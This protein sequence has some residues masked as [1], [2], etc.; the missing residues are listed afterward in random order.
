MDGTDFWSFRFTIH[1]VPSSANHHFAQ[2]LLIKGCFAA[3]SILGAAVNGDRG[4]LYLLLLWLIMPHRTDFAA[5]LE[6]FQSQKF[7]ALRPAQSAMLNEY[8][9][10]LSKLD[11]GVELPTGAGKTLIALLICEL[12]RRENKKVAVL[13]A[14]KTLARQMVAEAAALGVP[15]VL[16]EGP[17]RDIPGAD[18]RAYHRANSIAVMNYWVYFNQNPVLDPAGLLVMDDAHLAE[19]CLHSLDSVEVNKHDH[20]A[21]FASLVEEL[22]ERFPEYSVLSDALAA[23]VPAESTAELLSF[24][25]QVSAANRIREIVDSSPYLET[26]RDL[27]FRWTRLRQHLNEANIYISLTSI[28][29]RPYVYP[30]TANYQYQQVEQRLYVSATIGDPGDLSRRLGTKPI[31]KIPIAAEHAHQTYGCRLIVMNRIDDEDIPTRLQAVIIEALQI[32]PKS[33]WLCASQAE[34]TRVEQIVAAWLNANGLVGHPTWVLTSLGNEIDEFKRA[35][36]GHLFVGGR[37]DGMD[38]NADECRLVVLKTLPRAINTQEEFI[39]AYLRDSGFMRRR[40]N[41]RIVQALGRCNRSEDDYGVYVLADRRFATHFGRES[42]REGIPPNMVAEIDAAQDHAEIN[43]QEQLRQVRLFLN[44]DFADFDEQNR[45]Y[46]AEL[47]GQRVLA[48]GPDTAADEVSGWA[49]LFA[50]QN[51]EVAAEK[52]ETCWDLARRANVR[53]MAAFHGWTW[54]K[55]L[56]LQSL[57]GEANARERSLQCLEAAIA[58]GGQSSWFNR[59]RASVN[60]ARQQAIPAVIP[61]DY[62][63]VLLRSFDDLLERV[64]S[65]GDRFDRWSQQLTDGLRSAHHDQFAE[66]IE[67]LGM[68]L[69]FHATRPRHQAATDC[70]WR[71]VFGNEKEVVTFEVKIEHTGQVA[72]APADVGQAHNQHARAQAQYAPQGYTIRGTIVSHMDAIEPAADASAGSIRII[73]QAAT[74]ELWE[75]VRL[76]LSVYRDRWSLD[77]M[78]ARAAAAEGIRQRIPRTGWLIRALDYEERFVPV[79]RLRMEWT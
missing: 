37:F 74:A 12:W 26:D 65:T 39:S 23:D 75:R 4:H 62:A 72:I 66:A 47:P 67:R 55:A 29:I 20:E 14:N 8:N 60:R 71:G 5:F 46:R 19:H 17:G 68:L 43:E 1:L 64:G 25:D 76:L 53:E 6:T 78:N 51:Y 63:D 35:T 57:L 58:R 73:P 77:D 50:S 34:A 56:Y 9:D 22:R 15:A 2:T 10:F 13:S 7:R 21:L 48:A 31:E 40:L 45:R 52:F 69:G 61:T 18:K 27:R 33:V 11:V 49:A 70:R 3:C 41:Q 38:F 28:W 44:R 32:H 59:M 30:L 54:A 42:N 79:Q 36:R 24:L 16:M